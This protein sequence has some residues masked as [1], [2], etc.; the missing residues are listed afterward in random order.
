M[1]SSRVDSYSS[2]IDILSIPY[3]YILIPPSR[4]QN[5]AWISTCSY[6]LV[7]SAAP[8]TKTSSLP[9]EMGGGGE[10]WQIYSDV[11]RDEKLATDLTTVYCK[12]RKAQVQAVKIRVVNGNRHTKLRNLRNEPLPSSTTQSH[13][14]W[15]LHSP[16]CPAP[17]FTSILTTRTIAS[18]A[19]R[20][21]W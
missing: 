19:L 18:P 21:G 10:K 12:A 1:A 4:S 3:R 16:A 15:R 5:F 13:L 11:V 2:G 9:V 20:D 17:S 7:L 6:T 8:D 14:Q